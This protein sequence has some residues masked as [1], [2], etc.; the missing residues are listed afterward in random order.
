MK[1]VLKN[2]HK[3]RFGKLESIS[4]IH[5]DHMEPIY[6]VEHDRFQFLQNTNMGLLQMYNLCVNLHIEILQEHIVKR[7]S[8][9]YDSSLLVFVLII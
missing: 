5:D 6:L 8:L 1:D 2:I 7:H 4:T 9:H 3:S